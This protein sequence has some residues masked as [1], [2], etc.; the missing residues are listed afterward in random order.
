VPHTFSVSSK[1]TSC[2]DTPTFAMFPNPQMP[3]KN[4]YLLLI[5]SLIH[6]HVFLLHAY[7]YKGEN[8]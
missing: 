2:G 1:M 8:E 6:F 5:L 3:Y 4:S 7:Q